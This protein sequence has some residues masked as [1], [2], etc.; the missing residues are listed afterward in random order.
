MLSKSAILATG[1]QHFIKPY[2]LVHLIIVH[3]ISHAIQES[4]GLDPNTTE[5]EIQARKFEKYW[6]KNNLILPEIKELLK[7]H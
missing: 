5:S 6:C 7:I 1:A 2:E 3:E 4:C